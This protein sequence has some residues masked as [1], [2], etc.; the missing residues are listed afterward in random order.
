MY[1][2]DKRMYQTAVRPYQVKKEGPVVPAATVLRNR[3]LDEDS[4]SDEDS[5]DIPMTGMDRNA[6]QGDERNRY[7]RKT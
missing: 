7:Y 1:D 5:D 3:W 2:C 6:G 4:D